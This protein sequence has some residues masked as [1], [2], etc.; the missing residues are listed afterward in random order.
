VIES[1][2]AGV[3]SIASASKLVAADVSLTALEQTSML[4]C[5]GEVRESGLTGVTRNHVSLT[6][7][8]VRIPP[9]PPTSPRF[10]RFSAEF[11]GNPRKSAPFASL[12]AP[13]TADFAPHCENFELLS[14][15]RISLVPR[16]TPHKSTTDLCFRCS[17]ESD[18]PVVLYS[19]RV[20]S[21]QSEQR[22]TAFD[23]LIADL[24]EAIVCC[25]I[26]MRARIR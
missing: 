25:S 9:S 5:R 21:Q 12:A 26:R 18:A 15:M 11:A 13:E 23:T 4:V 19:S 8:G 6:A 10:Q 20:H 22:S 14:L 2:L 17:P 1:S 16:G 7:P 24:R 3:V